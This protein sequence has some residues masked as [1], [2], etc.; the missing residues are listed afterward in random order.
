MLQL[1]QREMAKVKVPRKIYEELTVI[2]REIHYTLDYSQVIKKAEDNGFHTTAEWL[3]NNE[4][5]YKRG[6]GR[7]FEPE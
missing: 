4:E 2:N 1:V 7:G 3:R 6:F 5:L